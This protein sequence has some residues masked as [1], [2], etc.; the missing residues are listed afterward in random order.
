M[1]ALLL[2][3]RVPP[4]FPFRPN[5]GGPTMVPSG[6]TARYSEAGGAITGVSGPTVPPPP[7]PPM[8]LAV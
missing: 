6:L 5:V 3:P 1:P 7:Q 4:G 8:L 2:A